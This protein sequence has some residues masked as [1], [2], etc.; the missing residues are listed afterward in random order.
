MV[1]RDFKPQNI[2]VGS[3][4]HAY[5]ADFGLTQA[6]GEPGLTR[7][8][9]FVGTLDY[10]AP[11]QIHGKP[12]TRRSDVYAFGAVLF[13]C[14]TGQGPLPARVRRRD[15]VR[16]RERAAAARERAAPR[17]PAHDR[18]RAQPRAGQEPRRAPADR[19]RGDGRARSRR[20]AAPSSRPRRRSPA[21]SPRRRPRPATSARSSARATAS[22][23]TP[24]AGERGRDRGR[25]PAER[26]QG[27]PA[28]GRAEEP[29]PDLGHAGDDPRRARR[30][31]RAPGS[32]S[33]RRTTRSP[34][35][36]RRSPRTSATSTPSTR[37]MKPV[38]EA[39]KAPKAQL[40]AE[41]PATQQAAAEALA[42]VFASASHERAGDQA[43][44][45][46]RR[47]SR[48]AARRAS[49]SADQWYTSVSQGGREQQLVRRS[50][51]RSTRPTEAESQIN[52]A[53]KAIYAVSAAAHRRAPARP[54]RRHAAA[55]RPR[56][57]D[58]RRR[59]R[60]RVRRRR[61]PSELEL[62]GPLAAVLEAHGSMLGGDQSLLQAGV[63]NGDTLALR[64]AADARHPVKSNAGP[65]RFDLDRRRRPRRGPDGLARPRRVRDR[66]RR[67]LRR[68]RRGPVD[69]APA[70]AA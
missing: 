42:K 9:Q 39:V 61:R 56:G 29:P 28:A 7:T 65:S 26:L 36:R 1:H 15:A 41:D 4:D 66:P 57:R 32:R 44:A 30:G 23:G 5:L 70:P 58:R 14:L 2:L 51:S 54:H 47:Q 55:A 21:R 49:A 12:A 62:R 50:T 35:R 34:T 69:V 6:L 20:S 38:P 48:E 11:E 53:L 19:D 25:P 67:E 64:P 63:R 18:R 40:A 31:R 17:R 22:F 46:R 60:R 68:R 8:G 24:A 37:S 43:A 10:I 16:P 33:P 3:R 45:G 13:E 27:R 52:A 59:H